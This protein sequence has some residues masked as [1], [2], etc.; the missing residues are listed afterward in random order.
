MLCELLEGLFMYIYKLLVIFITFWTLLCCPV[1][2]AA[3]DWDVK[4]D[5]WVA[6]DALGRDLPGYA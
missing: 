6:R 5:T 2:Y 1:L 4:S 3:V